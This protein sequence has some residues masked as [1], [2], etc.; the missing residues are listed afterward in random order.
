M[1][2]R[3][4][5]LDPRLDRKTT[6]ALV[7]LI[8]FMAITGLLTAALVVVIG[9][10]TFSDTYRY[11]A[12]FADVTSLVEGD[13]VRVAGVRV[14]TVDEVEV[15]SDSTA[16]VTFSV[17]TDVALTRSTH[18]DLRYRNMIGQRYLSLS[19]GADGDTTPLEPGEIIPLARTAPAL[20]LT[21]LFAG[22]KPLFQALSPE[23][24]NQLT[25]ELIQV[26]QGEGGT[27][28]SLLDSTAQ[29]TNTLADRDELIGDV[30]DNLTTVL[31]SFNE[32]DTELTTTIQTLQ[33]LI[34]G[35]NADRGALTGSLDDI[36]TLTKQTAG[37]VEDVRPDLS[38]D[39]K[40]LR[41]WT[42]QIGTKKNRKALD[43]T[44]TILPIKID[45][46]GATGQYGSFFNFYI[47]DLAVNGRLPALRGVPGWGQE[48]TFSTTTRIRVEGEGEQRCVR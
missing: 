11:R 33:Q 25:Y 18:A 34:S 14:G 16:E 6:G 15:A 30:I 48:R 21:V 22:F 17:D 42:A 41:A 35:L 32:R 3:R 43:R 19:E 46:L 5:K 10:V 13:D 37:L 23:D 44:L 12:V 24:T 2:N 9:N 39:L 8:I 26:L 7:K 47:C 4:R 31:S 20:D 36:A 29:V 27:V 38:T 28:E 45:R 40:H 1:T